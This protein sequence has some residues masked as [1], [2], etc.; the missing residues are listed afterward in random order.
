MLASLIAQSLTG[1]DKLV[2][3]YFEAEQQMMKTKCYIEHLKVKNKIL[4]FKK[5]SI[6]IAALLLFLRPVFTPFSI[7]K[8]KPMILNTTLSKP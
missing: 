8:R 2:C 5:F 6:G 3:Y 7:K 1:R 4:P